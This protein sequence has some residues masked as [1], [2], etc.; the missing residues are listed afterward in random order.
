MTKDQNLMPVLLNESS[1]LDESDGTVSF[2]ITENITLTLYVEEFLDFLESIED[3][4]SILINQENIVVGT[5]T[6][7]NGNQKD[8]LLIKPKEDEYN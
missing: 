8:Q 2:S 6:D 4:K 7:K 5:V 3:I 1:W